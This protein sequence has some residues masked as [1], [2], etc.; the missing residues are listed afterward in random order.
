M[1]T[2]SSGWPL[3]RFHCVSLSCHGKEKGCMDTSTWALT[4]C[5]GET[6]HAGHRVAFSH[7]SAR[8]RLSLIAR[9]STV[10]FSGTGN[11][12]LIDSGE[13]LIRSVSARRRRYSL[14]VAGTLA[15]ITNNTAHVTDSA[16]C[17]VLPVPAVLP[18]ICSEILPARLLLKKNDRRF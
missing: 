17:G 3:A 4:E 18:R 5:I 9:G 14:A 7:R 8:Y 16:L 13:P 2:D 11:T 1:Q 10:K 6:R 12:H 15:L